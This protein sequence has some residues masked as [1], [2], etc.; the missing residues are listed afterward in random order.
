[1]DQ[2]TKGEILAFARKFFE[3]KDLTTPQSGAIF[4]VASRVR[5]M[6]QE[7][8]SRSALAGAIYTCPMHP[9]IRHKGPGNCPICGMTLEPLA[10]TAEAGPRISSFR[11]CTAL[12]GWPGAGGSGVY[13]GD[14]RSHS[15]PG[16]H[17]CCL[18][19]DIELDSVRSFDACR[20]V[21]RLAFLSSAAGRR[22]WTAA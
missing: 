6:H 10:A 3:G 13:P 19:K 17:H 14:G 11:T 21:G 15:G 1:M 12:L 7:K 22:S 2:P 16:L 9:Q 4:G 18:A 8:P 5:A 20:P